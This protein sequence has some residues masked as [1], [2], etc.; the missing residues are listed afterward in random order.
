MIGDLFGLDKQTIPFNSRTERDLNSVHYLEWRGIM[1]SIRKSGML[2]ELVD[3]VRLD[4]TADETV[5]AGV[6]VRQ[7]NVQYWP[8]LKYSDIV[9]LSA[10]YL[11]LGST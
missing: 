4:I 3:L 5:A 11:S 1:N 10:D 9:F 6:L 8:D 2:N 7:Q